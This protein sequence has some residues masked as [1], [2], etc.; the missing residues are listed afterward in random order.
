MNKTHPAW[1]AIAYGIYSAVTV[2][3]VFLIATALINHGINQQA[4]IE[5][6]VNAL[7][8]FIIGVLTVRF[9]WP[10]IGFRPF[11]E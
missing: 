6:M 5:A 2:T 3:F 4:L 9:V 8:F 11:G 7:L 1:L 10:R